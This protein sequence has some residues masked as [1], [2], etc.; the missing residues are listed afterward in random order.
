VRLDF[1]SFGAFFLSSFFGFPVFS[2][3]SADSFS[4]ASASA[5]SSVLSSASFETLRFKIFILRFLASEMIK[6]RFRLPTVWDM[7]AA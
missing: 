2:T 5:D 1:V 3:L 7:R 6:A 4:T